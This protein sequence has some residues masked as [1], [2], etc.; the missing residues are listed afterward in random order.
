MK[1]NWKGTGMNLI[2]SMDITY[3][4]MKMERIESMMCP[5]VINEMTRIRMGNDKGKKSFEFW[6]EGVTEM[7]KVEIQKERES[8][9]KYL[10]EMDFPYTWLK[11][12]GVDKKYIWKTELESVS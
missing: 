1:H 7:L 6:K 8:F 5:K 10:T 2:I 11:R 12:C 4:R 9:E 3:R